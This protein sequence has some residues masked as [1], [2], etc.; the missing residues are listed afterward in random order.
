MENE[1]INEYTKLVWTAIPDKPGTKKQELCQRFLRKCPTP[2]AIKRLSRIEKN[3]INEW[4]PEM[5]NFFA[6]IELGKIVTKSHEEIIG[7]AYSS[8]EL[9]RKMVD[10]FQSEGQE[11]VCIAC[12]D[13]HNEII[14]WKILFVGGG[15]ECILYPD[16]I[17]QYALRCSAQG[18]I[19]IHNHP[20]GDIHPSKQDESFTRR[21]ER[22]CE[23]IGLHLVDFMIVGRD[24]YHSWREAS[25]VNELKK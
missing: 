24:T 14:D 7:H 2:L 12:T 9:G 21:L 19:M 13:I 16:K 22:G 5:L 15:C 1:V 6:A 11:S 17:F 25:L 8:I 4:A 10:H 23:I 3:E 18:I 20:T